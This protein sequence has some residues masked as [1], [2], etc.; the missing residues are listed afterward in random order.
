[1]ISRYQSR[2]G[3]L[4]FSL[5]QQ[6]WI[7]WDA[8]QASFSAAFFCCFEWQMYH[9]NFDEIVISCPARP[10]IGDKRDKK[11]TS[12]NETKAKIASGHRP[13]LKNRITNLKQMNF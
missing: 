10:T 8:G 11:L 4:S 13:K 7:K 3:R 9:L 1:M 2:D 12:G 6:C 5:N